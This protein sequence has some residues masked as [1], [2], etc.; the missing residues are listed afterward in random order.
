MAASLI[1]ERIQ[2]L[3]ATGSATSSSWAAS[4]MR[5]RLPSPWNHSPPRTLAP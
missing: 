1:L 3:R 2:N 4:C 5:G